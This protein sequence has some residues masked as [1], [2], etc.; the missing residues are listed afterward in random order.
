MIDRARFTR[1]WTTALV[2]FLALLTSTP[3]LALMHIDFEQPYYV[4]KEYQ[5]WDF[6]L[7]QHDSLYSIIYHAIPEDNPSPSEADHIYRATSDD[8]IHWS[9][10]WIILSVSDDLHETRAVWAPDVIW[11][12]DSGLWWMSYTGV[13]ELY[14]QRICVAWSHDLDTWYKTRLNPVMEP[15][16]PDFFY[17]ANAGW[18]ECRDPYYYRD[19]DQWHMLASAKAMGIEDGQGAVAHTTSTDMVRWDEPDIFFL[20]DGD[21][22]GNTLESVQYLVEDG[23][24]HLFFLEYSVQGIA[25]TASVRPEGLSMANK[26]IIALGIAPE[27]DCFD[28]GPT[29][30]FSRIVPYQEP[31]IT[32]R[33]YLTRIDSLRYG[34][35]TSEPTVIKTHPLLRE[36][37]S[38]EGLACL[39]NPT[40]GDNSA[41][42]GEAPANPT[43][44]CYFSTYEYYQ[45]PLSGYGVPGFFQG[46]DVQ[47]NAKSHP[48]VIE[49]KSISFHIGGTN[50]IDHTFM[51]L[52]DAATDSV[53]RR[54]TGFDTHTMTKRY[55]DIQDL[56]GREVFILIQDS[57][58]TGHI[59]IDEIV[60]SHD[61]VTTSVEPMTPFSTVR[62]LGPSPNPFNPSTRLRFEL[63]ESIS[64]R[65]TI[66]DLRGRRIWDSGVK[67]G[68]EGLN[69]VRWSGTNQLGASQPGGV[70]VYRIMIG[71]RP[72]ASG[73]L[74]LLP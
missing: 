7:I 22:P 24:H 12:E 33:S 4:H 17:F 23:I 37:A 45:G 54:A 63:P 43:G 66:H 58:T 48:F 6:C 65:V 16:P 20:N 18:S 32:A 56:L 68:Q 46:P 9:E 30:V 10:P 28:G 35:G 14:N 11:D 36:F 44:H 2:V 39:S 70:Y 61:E 5:T 21:Y 55:W 15:S 1:S 25:H 57:L 8:L 67:A 13:D 38:F 51:A 53:L 40:F 71:G 29:K 42:R 3:A 60:E 50:D 31:D 74:T 72:Q 27:V 41:R 59:N 52:V 34:E 73:K 49:G 62:D 19:G 64:Y 26:E 47:G 69:T